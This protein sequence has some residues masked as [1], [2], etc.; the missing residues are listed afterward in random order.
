ML[1]RIFKIRFRVFVAMV[2]GISLFF[3]GAVV[4]DEPRIF[5]KNPDPREL[6][7]FLFAEPV[8]NIRIRSWV[9]EKN[10]ITNV[11]ALQIYFEFDSVKMLPDSK[12]TVERL[13]QALI[14][15]QAGDEPIMI[16]GHTDSVGGEEY[17]LDL[18][19][20]RAVAIRERLIEIYR[21]APERLFVDGKGEYDLIRPES[22]KD[23][24]NRRVQIRHFP[25]K[26]S[27]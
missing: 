5:E 7:E 25:S 14:S 4:S 10:P 21:I 13:A 1:L 11:A 12:G 24:I 22:P 15:E 6:A 2:V 26:P 19:L 23:P 9:V 17:N 18:S 16:E 8:N 3:S 27:Q 20:D